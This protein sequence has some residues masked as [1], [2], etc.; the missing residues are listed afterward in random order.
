MYQ[1]KLDQLD[2]LENTS[3]EKQNIDQLDQIDQLENIN[4]VNINKVLTLDKYSVKTL[5]PKLR[6]KK[7]YILLDRRFRNEENVDRTITKWNFCTNANVVNGSVNCL[8]D[9]KNIISIKISDFFINLPNSKYISMEQRINICIHEL[10]GQSFIAHEN[11]KFHFLGKLNS[12]LVTEPPSYLAMFSQCNDLVGQYESFGRLS[13][14][15]NG[16]YTFKTPITNLNSISISLASSMQKIPLNQD[17]YEFTYTGASA[18]TLTPAHNI[19][20]S[21]VKFRVYI[22]NFTTDDPTAD[23][24]IIRLINRKNGLFAQQTTTSSLV[25][26]AVDEETTGLIQTLP[27]LIGN[28]LPGATIYLDYYRFNIPMEITYLE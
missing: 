2:Q 22:D 3:K 5:F 23:E 12:N 21:S 17:S 24:F 16:T 25:L 20:V 19:N 9:V 7:A 1:N 11:R 26:I 4:Q 14:Y 8:A 15:N 6:E 10:T 27:A 28:Q 18:I 13:D